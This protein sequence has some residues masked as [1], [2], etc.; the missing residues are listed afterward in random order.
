MDR[1]GAL[2]VVRGCTRVVRVLRGCK[3]SGRGQ[4]G[5]GGARGRKGARGASV[6]VERAAHPNKPKVGVGRHEARLM[7]SPALRLRS[8]PT[9]SAIEVVCQPSGC[10]CDAHGYSLGTRVEE[11]AVGLLLIRLLMRAVAELGV[12][13]S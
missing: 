6:Q 12:W 9:S 5:Q 7:R 11:R 4:G 8:S 3:G 10:S 13:P 2:R 1:E